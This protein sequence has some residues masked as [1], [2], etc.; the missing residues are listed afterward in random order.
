VKRAVIVTGA[1]GFIG[2]HLVAALRDRASVH[3]FSSR[4][5]RGPAGATSHRVDLRAAAAVALIRTIRPSVIYHLAGPTESHVT[6]P[7]S[8]YYEA[9]VSATN[10]VLDAALGVPRVRVVLA[11]S[12]KE[13]GS[14]KPSGPRLK[15]SDPPRPLTP[16]AVAKLA[17]THMARMYHDRDGLRVTTL[18]LFPVFGPAMPEETLIVRAIRAALAGR[19]LRMT[20]GLQQRDL[21]YIDDV[22]RAFQ[23]ASRA[24]APYGE[25]LNICTGRAAPVRDIVRSI[26]AMTSSPGRPRPGAL[27][28]PA[29]EVS[30]LCGDPSA[31]RRR[32]GWSAGVS[33]E[34]GLQRTVDWFAAHA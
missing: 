27:T 4:A 2:R 19:D 31:A 28:Y 9:I 15:E 16:Y 3:V 32:L 22:V 18:R 26:Y 24:R 13:Y 20:R 29:H 25:V 12:A 21:V 30:R 6:L 17:C 10:N 7:D 14:A 1:S 11:G 5:T 33:L 8:T 34:E 23:A